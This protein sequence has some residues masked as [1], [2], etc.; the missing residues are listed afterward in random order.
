LHVSEITLLNSFIWSNGS[1]RKCRMV[2]T[3]KKKQLG[4]IVIVSEVCMHCAYFMNFKLML[5]N[6]SKSTESGH[7]AWYKI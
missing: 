5:G 4:K 6:H 2:K 3:L 7:C 1:D